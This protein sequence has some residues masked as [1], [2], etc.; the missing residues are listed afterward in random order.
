MTYLNDGKWLCS[1]SGGVT[2]EYP[3]YSNAAD[4]T[5]PGCYMNP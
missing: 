4:G 5:T 1:G 3:A 2:A